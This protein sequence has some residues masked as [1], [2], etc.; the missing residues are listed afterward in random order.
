M[1]NAY[2][3]NQ[4]FTTTLNVGGGIDD[5]QTTGIIITSV[6][7]LDI[8]KPGIALINY[9][10]P[11]NTAIAEWVTY[12]SINGSNELQ[13]VTR[14]AEGF[15]AKTH[16]NSVSV[17]FPLSESHVNNLATSLSIGGIST[18][19]VTT[20]LDED[21]MGSDSATALATQ[22]S[23]KAYV[24]AN[25]GS[26]TGWTDASAYTWVYASASTFTIAGVDL[27]GTFTKGTRLKWTQ[28][29]VKYGV[30][31]DSSFSTDTTV[32]IATNTDYT[33]ANAAISANYYSYQINPQGYPGW[34]NVVAPTYSGIDD[35]AGGQPTITENRMRVDGNMCKAHLRGVGT[36]A[37]SSSNWYFTASVYPTILN[38]T[39]RSPLGVAYYQTS[40]D[41]NNMMSIFNLS[42]NIY[43]LHCT[44]TTITDNTSMPNFG[45][46]ISYEI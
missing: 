5:S 2:F 27:T 32:T 3:L 25:A 45:H 14:G 41:S 13:G 19:L 10:D 39:P 24:D 17:A 21:A 36:K 26:A 11:L 9:A 15:S 30:V 42:T 16:S 1:A 37:G 20:T 31:I 35:G 29:T 23:I 6:S 18:N 8:T 22:Q 12:T 28:T 43:S 38:H 40:G 44:E 4:Y 34:F 7:G 46:N 33:I